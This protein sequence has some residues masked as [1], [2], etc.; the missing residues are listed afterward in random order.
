VMR[1]NGS[2]TMWSAVEEERPVLSAALLLA[3]P[4]PSMRDTVERAVTVT[5][6][7]SLVERAACSS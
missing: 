6:S 7:S 3:P 5:V 4:D 2:D 1:G